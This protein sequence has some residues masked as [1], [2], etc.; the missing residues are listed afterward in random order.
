[1]SLFGI[2][3]FPMFWGL[4]A[5]VSEGIGGLLLVV[6]LFYRPACLLLMITMSVAAVKLHHDHADFQSVASRP[7]ELAF[8]F[9][10]LAFIGP[11]KLSV[12][13]D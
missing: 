5:A 6:G 9:L 7:I 8:V 11:G 12:D 3:I 4:M 2:D 1:M 10:G 13:K